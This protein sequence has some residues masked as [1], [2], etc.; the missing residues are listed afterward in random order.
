MEFAKRTGEKQHNGPAQGVAVFS[1]PEKKDGQRDG[2]PP[3]KNEQQRQPEESRT[4]RDARIEDIGQ[5]Q[6]IGCR[7]GGWIGQDQNT[8]G[9]VPC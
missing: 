7:A 5:A 2:S 4:K 1:E 8:A 6:Q 9:R 3:A